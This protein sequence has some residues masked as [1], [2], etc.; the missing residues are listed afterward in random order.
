MTGLFDRVCTPSAIATTD[1]A[2]RHTGGWDLADGLKAEPNRPFPASRARPKR[3]CC[4][5]QSLVLY[6]LV[7]R[8]SS[9]S[10]SLPSEVR[11]EGHVLKG[12]RRTLLED[13]VRTAQSDVEEEHLPEVK[14]FF[15]PK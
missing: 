4:R 10:R 13:A 1:R 9:W 11:E 8:G 7:Q 14:K 3:A 5:Y 2:R 6:L 12:S 15:H